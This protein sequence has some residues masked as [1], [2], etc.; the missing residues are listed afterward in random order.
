MGKFIVVVL[1]S[2][3]V[4]AM[5]DVPQV[6][7][8]DIGS[9]TCK[10]IFES[11]ENLYL[12]NLEK[13][14]LI[15]ALGEEITTMKFSDQA[16]YGT[17]DLMHH[18]ADTFLGHQ[19]IMG[20]FPQM[21]LIQPFREVI[22]HVATA[23]EEAGHVVEYLGNQARMLFVDEKVVVGDNLETDLGQV[24]NV[25]GCIDLIS[26]EEIVA[27]G[28]IVR[29][30]VKV[31]RVIALGG[32]AV[33]I[34]QVLSAR[35]EIDGI[36]A[37]INTPESGLY[38]QNYR[39]IH[40]GYG[41]NALVQAPTILGQQGI[42]V[43]LIGK[44]ADIVENSHGRLIPGV[45]TDYLFQETLAEV[46]RMKNGFIC[47]NIQETDLAG[48]AQDAER[49]ANRLIVSDRYIG[50]MMNMLSEDDILIVMADHGNDPTIGHAQ[51]TREKVPILV[52]K[53]GLTSRNIGK[54]TTMSDIGATVVDYFGAQPTEN[55]QSFLSK[56]Q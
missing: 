4:G 28:R 40:L 14:G 42:E 22:D 9:N 41:V 13:I 18:G 8:E 10:H 53:P 34:E 33:P 17:S 50:E 44:V 27:I 31:S 30:T 21:P 3:G 35:R 7:P 12:P 39:V 37:G 2:F 32:E 38:H 16:V 51:H 49:Y 48:H 6:R 25:S 24:Y 26:F 1:D 54:L 45:D 29:E 47:L 19:E 55:G 20:T 43:T 5:D 52:Y 56:I 15:N 23:L 46:R 11:Q 36:Y